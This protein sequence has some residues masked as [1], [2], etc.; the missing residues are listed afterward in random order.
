MV[1]KTVKNMHDNDILQYVTVAHD[2][3]E[4]GTI[5]GSQRNAD[6]STQ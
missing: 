4:I 1:S 5:L 2:V 3:N 6:L